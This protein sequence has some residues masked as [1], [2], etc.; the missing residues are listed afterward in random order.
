M[1]QVILHTTHSLKQYET[2][3]FF[4]FEKQ[5]HT[6]GRGKVIYAFLNGRFSHFR[7][8]NFSILFHNHMIC[9]FS[10]YKFEKLARHKFEKSQSL[11]T[12]YPNKP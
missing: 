12:I 10:R 9:K 2:I 6:Q 11:A 8:S 7:K 5:T 3:T 4:F 1:E